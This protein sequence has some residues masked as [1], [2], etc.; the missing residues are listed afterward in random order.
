MRAPRRP[1][2]QPGVATNS[3]TPPAAIR[4]F[5][6]T[7]GTTDLRW[8]WYEGDIGVALQHLDVLIG[9]HPRQRLWP[10][11]LRWIEAHHR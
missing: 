3:W 5:A 7:A 1:W 4:P 8:L 11:I 2:R 9:R 6:A 10:E